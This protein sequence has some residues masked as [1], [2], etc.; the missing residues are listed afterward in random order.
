MGRI[1]E[2]DRFDDAYKFRTP[3]LRNVQHTAPY[4]HN[5]AYNTLEGIISHHADLH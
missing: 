5:G 3:S 4:G 1:N 2:S